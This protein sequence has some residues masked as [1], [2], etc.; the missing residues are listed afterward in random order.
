MED[1]MGRKD[2]TFEDD[3]ASEPE[4]ESPLFA[5]EATSVPSTPKRSRIAPEQLPLGLERADFHDVERL[6][7]PNPSDANKPG[8]DIEVEADGSEWSAEDDRI[9]VEL[10]LEKLNLTKKEWQECARNLGR[11]RQS[12]NRRWKSLIAHGDI[13][14]KPRHGGRSKLH[15]T[16]R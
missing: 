3:I 4:T 6:N 13:G 15:S 12:V 16:W 10:V 1:D 2:E 9:L 14:L 5:P 11:D 8:T 7:G